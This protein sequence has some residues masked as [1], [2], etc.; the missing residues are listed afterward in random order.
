MDVQRFNTVMIAT[1]QRG[2]SHYH[3]TDFNLPSL[4][5]LSSCFI[6]LCVC[7]IVCVLTTEFL[8]SSSSGGSGFLL[9]QQ[10]FRRLP[11]EK[12]NV[13]SATPDRINTA[14]ILCL[15]TFATDV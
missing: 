15:R 5:L 8:Q 7:L 13:Y 6:D 1:C 4:S 12:V 2:I 14:D 9:E 11:R 10:I 3:L